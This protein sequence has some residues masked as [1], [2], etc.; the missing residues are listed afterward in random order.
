MSKTQ[1]CLAFF[2]ELRSVYFKIAVRICEMAFSAIVDHRT[3]MCGLHP[4]S[5]QANQT[6]ASLR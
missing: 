1:L 3:Q 4:S 2:C 5:T 6:T